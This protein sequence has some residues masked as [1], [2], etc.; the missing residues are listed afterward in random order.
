MGVFTDSESSWAGQRGGPGPVASRP[1]RGWWRETLSGDSAEAVARFK[2]GVIESSLL[3]ESSLTR[4][5]VGRG[6]W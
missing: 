3:S 2:F 6:P 4:S 5:E 1:C